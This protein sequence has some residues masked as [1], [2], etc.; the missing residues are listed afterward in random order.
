MEQS[1]DIAIV[2]GGVIGLTAAYY[3]SREGLRVGVFDRQ[4]LGHEASWAGAGILPPGNLEKSVSPLDRLRALSAA[5][6]P[7]LS[8]ELREASDVDNGY[9]R[10]GRLEFSR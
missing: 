10:C 8:N 5:E 3:L 2:G 7:R 1:L 6:F 4:K 9:M